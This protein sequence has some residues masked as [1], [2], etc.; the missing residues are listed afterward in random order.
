[1]GAAFE[2]GRLLYAQKR[3]TMAADEFRKEL[4]SQPNN[5]LAMAFLGLS[6]T[7]DGQLEAGIAATQAAVALAPALAFTHYALACAIIGPPA[8]PGSS[9]LRRAKRVAYGGRLRRATPAALEA[10]RLSPRNADFLAL[11][12]AIE[13]E[14]LR[15]T[16]ALRWAEEGLACQA[17][18]VRCA[19]IRTRALAKLGHAEAAHETLDAALALAP[20]S[21]ETHATG[22]WTHL[23]TGDARQASE[24]FEEALRLN[25]ND[26][27]SKRGLD[28][29]I[30]RRDFSWI[31]AFAIFLIAVSLVIIG[32]WAVSVWKLGQGFFTV[33]LTILVVFVHRYMRQR[34]S[35]RPF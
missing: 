8:Q 31:D 13:F 25:P 3:Y 14:L 34:L 10:V 19:I 22:G 33:Y 28:L 12:A 29:A 2:R 11:V 32:M 21:A 35:R 17:N 24:H 18:H 7:Y 20:E 16:S 9:I 23:N 4:S 27:H 30:M 6:L 1:M 26:A 15:P 5:A